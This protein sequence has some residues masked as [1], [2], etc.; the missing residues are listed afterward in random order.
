MFDV[1]WLIGLALLDILAVRGGHA[2]LALATTFGLLCAASVKL[3]LRFGLSGVRYRR[4]LG[5]ERAQLGELVTLS[6]TFSNHKLL[7]LSLL[8]IYDVL[9]RHVTV[10]GGTQ[11]DDEAG[12]SCLYIARAMTPYARI[13]RH[14]Q[15]R[16]ERRG[17]HQFGPVRY[18]T[19]DF[20]GVSHTRGGDNALSSLLVLPKIF[21]L[22]L[23]GLESRQ[24]L[25]TRAARNALADPLKKL[26]TRQYRAGDPLRAVDW[27]ATARRAELMVR[28]IE[29]STSPELQIVLDFRVREPAGDDHV[30][31]DELEY[32][33]SLAASL[34]AHCSAHGM[35]VGLC[36][37]GFC[38]G[39]LL[40]LPPSR[41][42][43][44]VGHVLE[45]LA[46][47]TS[48]PSG[49]LASLL[50]QR[51]RSLQ[52]ASTWLVISE[53][54]DL[55]EQALLRDAERR[56]HAVLVVSTQQRR[57]P[58]PLRAVHAPYALGW[59]ERDALRL[60]AQA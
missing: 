14:V 5:R 55:P 13:T 36:G 47:V 22:Q 41:A 6:A 37:N 39:Q 3:W 7:P 49:T 16:C 9:P 31:P 57:T 21:P 38:S 25:G 10:R 59:S 60:S 32:A 33:I 27:R 8:E 45:L 26:G 17:V 12:K 52:R 34:A 18:Q 15:V 46:R 51:D 24:L 35:A 20:L 50:A 28:E 11:R 19:G 54:L 4:V 30:E 23:V 44:Q 48:R 2:L 40:A 58:L 53:Q 43:E 1:R 29:P 56:G 42:P